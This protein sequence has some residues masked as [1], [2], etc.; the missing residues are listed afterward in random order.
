MSRENFDKGPAPSTEPL[1]CNPATQG[2]SIRGQRQPQNRPTYPK[3]WQE[4]TTWASSD[5][6]H[7]F[8][9]G[10]TAFDAE[11]DRPKALGVFAES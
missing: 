8:A 4:L 3:L 5:L 11:S 7:V 1:D 2:F 9:N 6:S 10:D